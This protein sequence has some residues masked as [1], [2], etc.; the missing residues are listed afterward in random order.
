MKK[1]KRGLLLETNRSLQETTQQLFM[2]KQELEEKNKEL[3]KARKREKLQKEKLEQLENSAMK[4]L[5]GPTTGGGDKDRSKKKLTKSMA[6]E[7]SLRYLRILEFYIKNKD[8]NVYEPLVE[9]L[10]QTLMEYGITPKGI[11]SM[12][13]KT[14]PQLRTM[15]DLETQRTT[16]ESRMV[17]LKVMAQYAS[18]LLRK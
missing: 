17:L 16:F 11:V 12:H 6:E 10:C 2:A 9:E 4:H 3:E 13:L 18:L 15:G 14:V 8:L 7:I 1:T 5:A